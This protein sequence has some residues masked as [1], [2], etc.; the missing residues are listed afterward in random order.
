MRLVPYYIAQ[1]YLYPEKEEALKYAETKLKGGKS[2]YYDL[3]MK[4]MIG[5]SY[6]ERKE[7][8]K[9]LPFLEDYVTK[10]TAKIRREDLYELSY[11][12]YKA[13]KLNKA[14]EGFKQL[15]GKE[16]SLSQNAMY[17]LWRCL[18]SRTNQNQMQ[19]MPSF[20]ASNSSDKKQ[21]EISTYQ[22]VKLSCMN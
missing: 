7:Y 18:I 22:Y 20:C 16:D 17:L 2:Q 4:Q 1:I 9:A 21:Q 5:H 15:S 11:S 14:I 8:D 12:Y 3:E 6:F 19:E 10:S 13:N